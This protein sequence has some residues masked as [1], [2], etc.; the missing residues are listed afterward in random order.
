MHA[1]WPLRERRIKRSIA[2][3][4]EAELVSLEMTATFRTLGL[5]RVRGIT[6]TGSTIVT[7]KAFKQLRDTPLAIRAMCCL[8]WKRR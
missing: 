6:E 1:R 4:A 5:T 7:G 2:A 8:R 3:K